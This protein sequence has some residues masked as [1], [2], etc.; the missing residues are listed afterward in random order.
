M[1]VRARSLEARIQRQ[2]GEHLKAARAL[3]ETARTKRGLGLTSEAA[4][5]AFVVAY[6]YSHDRFD[7]ERAAKVLETVPV[8]AE[9]IGWWNYW[10]AI[11]AKSSGD[12]RTA[13]RHFAQARRIAL[14]IGLD[15]LLSD[16]LNM[17][18][19]LLQIIGR[20]DA[21]MKNIQAIE[22]AAMKE[23][24]CIR[25]MMLEAV[26]EY[27]S[28]AR[29]AG[30]EVPDPIESFGRAGLL[31]REACADQSIV[32]QLWAKLGRAYLARGEIAAAGRVLDQA[33]EVR[34]NAGLWAA[35]EVYQLEGEVRTEQRRFAEA[36]RALSFAERHANAG[37]RQMDEWR[38]A[39]WL[40]RNFEATDEPE[41]ARASY[42]RAE[43]LLDDWRFRVPLGSGREAFA[44]GYDESARR[45][46]GLELGANRVGVAMQAARRARGRLLRSVITRTRRRSSEW[47]DHRW[48]AAVSRFLALQSEQQAAVAD[49]WEAPA[50]ITRERTRSRDE[51]RRVA[52]AEIEALLSVPGLSS[53]SSMQPLREDTFYLVFHPTISGWVAFGA[54][55]GRAEA[56]QFDAEGQSLESAVERYVV[57]RFGAAMSAAKSVVVLPYGRTNTIDIH[58]M[59]WRGAP[60]AQAVDIVYGLDLEHRPVAS[61]AG[62]RALVVSDPNNDLSFARREGQ[63]VA[64]LISQNVAILS[65]ADATLKNIRRAMGGSIRNFHYAGHALY[66]G[67]DG[68]E[69][70]LP[71]AQN[72]RWTIVDI[73]T[74]AAPRHVFLSGCSTATTSQ[75]TTSGMGLGQAFLMA[76]ASS[77]VATTR[78]VDD[79]FARRVAIE[80]HRRGFHEGLRRIMAS[81]PKSDWAAYRQ[82][83]P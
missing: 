33:I 41:H 22:A 70:H 30:Y 1:A 2:R 38:A 82:I 19:H 73:L 37:G 7:L 64:A 75:S 18:T 48:Q 40:G 15:E 12:V 14:R 51:Q 67:I 54:I 29:S 43:A 8:D 74:T 5:D 24:P 49:A 80:V 13:T 16:S 61:S 57:D 26:G 56:I 46:V 52:A 6:I 3:E 66:E 77:V 79:Q 53:K 59:A 42:E 21:S 4:R 65:G 68:W 31:M 44:G 25:G 17:E 9:S 34:P 81:E 58:A 50:S 76:G 27:R 47:S 62:N 23:P 36:R 78:P 63:D 10:R 69:S 39:L 60:L 71:L 20:I 55:D 28:V 35:L 11:V 45:I 83:I 32:T 72:G